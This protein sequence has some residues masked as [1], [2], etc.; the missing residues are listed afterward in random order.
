MQYMNSVGESCH[1]DHPLCAKCITQAELADA[2]T[3]RRHR[4]P[5][6]GIETLLNLIQF[7]TGLTPSVLREV[8]YPVER[9]SVKRHRL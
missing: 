3:D 2:R 1:V 8:A 7:M 9:I 5:I 6:T 4:L